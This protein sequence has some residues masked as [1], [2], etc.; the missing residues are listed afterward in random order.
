MKV[1]FTGCC[2]KLI[3]PN[4]KSNV[5][6][7]CECG[8]SW[9]WWKNP[10]AGILKVYIEGENNIDSNI[11]CL[12]NG[13]FRDTGMKSPEHYRELAKTAEGTVFK[14]TESLV[15]L[16]PVGTTNDVSYASDEEFLEA[17]GNLLKK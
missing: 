1:L 6:T 12:H 5:P 3:V 4:S 11:L 16:V 14:E 10:I 7:K 13:I 17:R 8:K 15:V 2:G 9:V